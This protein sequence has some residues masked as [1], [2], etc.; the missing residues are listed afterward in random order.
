[1]QRIVARAGRARRRQPTDDLISALVTANVEGHRLNSRELGSF[2]SLLLVAGVETTRNAISHGLKMLTDHPEQRKLLV[3]DFDGH[4]RGAVEEI[5]R[6]AS[7][8]IQFRRTLACD[9]DLHGHQF[10]AGDRVVLFYNS[11]NRDEAVFDAPNTFDI[12]RKPN[13]HLGFGGG[14]PHFC[15]GAFLAR[16]EMAVLFRE[17][18][19]QLPDIHS[20]GEPDLIASNFDNRVR[21]LRFAF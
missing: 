7:P 4:V 13:P 12:T 21:R 9:Y 20:V 3:S 6:F 16:Q 8:I 5:I 11:A 19:T 14:G 1:M 18:F 2:F 10:A 17:L 15:L